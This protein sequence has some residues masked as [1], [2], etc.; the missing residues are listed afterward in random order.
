MNMYLN[1]KLCSL[2]VRGLR[3]SAKRGRFVSWSKEK[4][5]VIFLQGTNSSKDIDGSWSSMRDGACYHSYGSTHSRGG[6][7]FNQD[8]R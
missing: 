6:I 4:G 7:Y 1:C 2:N 3:E 5:D 8:F